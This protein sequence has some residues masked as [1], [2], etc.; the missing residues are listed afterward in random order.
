IDWIVDLPWNN[1]KETPIDIEEAR[2]ILDEDHFGLEKPKER[3]LEFLAVQKLATKLK[4]PILCL[5]GPPGVGKTSLARSIARATNREFVR[6]SLGGVRD[7]AEIRGH[8]RTYVGALPGK[9]IQSLK[10]V[11]F[12]NPLFCLDE[13]DKMSTDF[14]GDPS[15]ALLEVL[16]PEQNG[17]FNDHYLD[18]DY[19]LSQVFFITTANSLQSIPLPLQDRMEI[20]QLP[21]YLETEKKRIAR[22]FLLPK[23]IEQHGITKDNL[24]MS[25]NVVMD[26]IRYYTREAGVRNL[27]REIASICRKAAMR[28]VEA[29]DMSKLVTV[30][31]QNLGNMLG[32]KKY[33]YGERE[34]EAQVGVTTGLAWT[35]LGGELLMVETA[36]MPGSGKVSITGK[37]GEVMTESAQAALSYIRSRSGLFGL[38][39]DFHKS[40]DIHV[41]VPE[42]ATPKDGPSAGITLCTS[43]V[44]ALLGISV[45]NDIAMTGEITLRGRV[46]PIGGLR[47]KLLAARRGLITTVLIPKDNEKDLKD[48]PADVLKGMTIIPVEN[49]DEVLPYAL[50]ATSEEIY[51]GKSQT[52]E[53]LESLK[54]CEPEASQVTH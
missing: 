46:L 2:T 16:D 54:I 19:D 4:G 8:R 37:L 7:E 11:D 33:R 53:L 41:H 44:S 35:E 25:D 22:D 1:L 12:N 47:E 51:Q 14:R 24:R 42:G 13:I 50:A 32:V 31:T 20:I 23:Q 36:I 34:D 43:M 3:I 21:G 40:V 48:I 6:L 38:K 15:A 28:V 26:I 29:D 27:E 10:R 39:G 9:I 45:R 30:S 5:V 17:T 49:V 18:L 52:R